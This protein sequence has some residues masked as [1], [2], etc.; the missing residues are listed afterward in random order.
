MNKP[1]YGYLAPSGGNLWGINEGSI[2]NTSINWFHNQLSK[3]LESNKPW[4]MLMVHLTLFSCQFEPN[5][6]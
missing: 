3:R 6:P 1:V 2:I 5:L 4:V